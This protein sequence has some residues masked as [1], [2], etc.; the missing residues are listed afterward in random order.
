MKIECPCD[1]VTHLFL[2]IGPQHA[3]VTGVL[4]LG[5]LTCALH[6]TY[7]TGI[8]RVSTN[9]LA[10][11]VTEPWAIGQVCLCGAFSALLKI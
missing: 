8:V 7:T 5:P 10:F 6:F 11:S 2:P 1:S 9:V 3:S 4:E